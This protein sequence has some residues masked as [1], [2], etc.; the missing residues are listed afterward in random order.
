MRAAYARNPLPPNRTATKSLAYPMQPEQ[1]MRRKRQ[2]QSIDFAAP[3]RCEICTA[4]FAAAFI[5]IRAEG[6]IAKAHVCLEC[7][8]QL[9]ECSS[10]V[11]EMVS[12]QD[13][14]ETVESHVNE[15]ECEPRPV[16]RRRG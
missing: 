7:C 9:Q 6:F 13:Y 15:L 3:D 16:S 1:G 14:K 11:V 5:I 4:K 10:A 2:I 8:A 12:L